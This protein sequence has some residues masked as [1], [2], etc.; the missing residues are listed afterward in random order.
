VEEQPAV[1][2]LVVRSRA[3]PAAAA[4]IN[5]VDVGRTGSG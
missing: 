3:A 1:S 4:W 2:T 5:G